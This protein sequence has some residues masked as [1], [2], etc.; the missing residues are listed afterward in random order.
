MPARQLVAAESSFAH[1]RKFVVL[2]RCQSSNDGCKNQPTQNPGHLSL[3]KNHGHKVHGRKRT[4]STG[5]RWIQ[6]FRGLTTP[7]PGLSLLAEGVI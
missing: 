2:R 7:G 6:I 3:L 4:V 5:S 1:S